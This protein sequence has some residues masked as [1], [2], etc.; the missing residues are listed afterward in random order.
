M[1]IQLKYSPFFDGIMTWL[2]NP[3][4][5]SNRRDQRW[6]RRMKIE[7]EQFLSDCKNMNNINFML[8]KTCPELIDYFLPCLIETAQSEC[9]ASNLRQITLFTS[10]ASGPELRN[11]ISISLKSLSGRMSVKRVSELLLLR[12]DIEK[13]IEYKYY[14]LKY[15]D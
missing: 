15:L 5:V 3:Q 9:K 10:L 12:S 13:I 6:V 1:S 4:N 7:M 2:F 8:P 14:S 11:S